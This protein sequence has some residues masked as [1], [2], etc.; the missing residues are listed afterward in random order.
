V[1][2]AEGDAFATIRCNTT[3]L[4]CACSSTTCSPG[5]AGGG[6][7]IQ[8]DAVVEDFVAR[9]HPDVVRVTRRHVQRH[10]ASRSRG[11]AD[12]NKRPPDRH[13]PGA[14]AM[15]AMVSVSWVGHQAFVKCS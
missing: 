14:V 1:A 4:P 3:G 5:E 12:P 7:E 6:C 8:R 13:R 11:C 15:A 9:T 2:R 10:S